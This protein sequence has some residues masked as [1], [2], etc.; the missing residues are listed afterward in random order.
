MEEP[1]QVHSVGVVGF[2]AQKVVPNC[3]PS[4]AH[5][6]ADGAETEPALKHGSHAIC[7]M[8]GQG[9]VAAVIMKFDGMRRSRDNFAEL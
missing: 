5:M 9:F 8:N 7:Y 3:V 6:P 2:A 1:L 4:I